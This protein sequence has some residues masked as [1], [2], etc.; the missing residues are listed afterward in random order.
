MNP[1]LTT[2]GFNRYAGFFQ[3]DWRISK[4]VTLN[5]GLRYEYEPPQVDSHNAWG[6]FDPNSPTGMVQQTNGNAL[7]KTD[8]RDFG[9][10]VGFAWDVTGKGTTVIRA[11]TSIAYDTVP[12]DALVTFQGASLPSIPTGFTL[13][14]ADGTHST[15]SRDHPVRR[16]RLWA[17]N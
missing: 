10:R 16:S 2:T 4:T 14:N 6:N 15:E 8:K 5:L 13:Y 3:D 9:P 12:M 11:G 7:Y 1:P 17:L